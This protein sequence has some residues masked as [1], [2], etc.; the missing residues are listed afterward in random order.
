MLIGSRTQK[1]AVLVEFVLVSSLLMLLLLSTC[2]V[3]I[4]LNAR[5]VLTSAAREGARR[6]AV[7]GGSTEKVLEKIREEIRFGFMD[8]DAATVSVTPKRASYGTYITV[9]IDYQ[10]PMVTPFVREIVGTHLPLRATAISR[11]EKVQ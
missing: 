4:I 6:A 9:Q 1:G 11:S 8:P 10:Y 7:E 3:G 5:I 2:E